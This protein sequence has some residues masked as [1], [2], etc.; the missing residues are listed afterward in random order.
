MT[1]RLRYSS[2]LGHRLHRFFSQG[3][4]LMKMIVA[5]IR[6]EKLEAVQRR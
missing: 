3:Y 5:I 4:P 2:R 6:P 1:P